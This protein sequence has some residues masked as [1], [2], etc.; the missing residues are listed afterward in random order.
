MKNHRWTR[1]L[2][3][4]DASQW[5][6]IIE[7]TARSALACPRQARAL[8][9]LLLLGEAGLRAAEAL[10]LDLADISDDLTITVHAGKGGKP[11]TV[12]LAPARATALDRYVAWARPRLCPSAPTRSG[13]LIVGPHGRLSY[14]G[15]YRTVKVAAGVRPHLLRHSAASRWLRAGMNLVHVQILLG[16]SSLATTQIYLHPTLDEV[17]ASFLL[18]SGIPLEQALPLFGADR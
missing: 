17:R 4:L 13:P 15:L 6:T 8:V 11:R 14:W 2:Q 1:P 7:D 16:H 18:A 10:A 3:I 9:A 12:F 5:G